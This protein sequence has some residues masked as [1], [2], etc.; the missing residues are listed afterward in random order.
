MVELQGLPKLPWELYGAEQVRKSVPFS[1]KENRAHRISIFFVEHPFLC[2][3]HI[4]VEASLTTK[5]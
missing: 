3:P 1:H 5:S 2:H 4:Q